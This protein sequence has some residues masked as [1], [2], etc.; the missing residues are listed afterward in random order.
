M[1]FKTTLSLENLFW[2]HVYLFVINKDLVATL[3]YACIRM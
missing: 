2:T 3:E 1:S